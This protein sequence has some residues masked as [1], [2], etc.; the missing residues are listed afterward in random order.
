MNS[1]Q[2]I[3]AFLVFCCVS[4]ILAAATQLKTV[5]ATTDDN[6]NGDKGIITSDE[7]KKPSPK[8]CQVKVQVKVLSAINGTIYTVQLDDLF[9]QSKQAV[10]NQTQIDNGDNNVAFMFQFKKGG[11]SCPEKD[12]T[13][14]GSVNTYGFAAYINSLTKPNKVWVEIP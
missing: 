9:P 2:L 10:F 13:V 14:L 6:G 8:I 5:S 3:F 11:D 12:S 4:P 1:K 7:A